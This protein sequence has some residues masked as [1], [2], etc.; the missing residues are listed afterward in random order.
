MTTYFST[1]IGTKLGTD[2][3]V[4]LYEVAIRPQG[5]E[6]SKI[7]G[8]TYRK[9]KVFLKVTFAQMSK[10]MQQ[11]ARFQ[12]K[13]LSIT[14]LTAQ[15]VELTHQ[16]P[17][18]PW[19]VEILTTEPRCLYYF[20]PFDNADEARF[21]QAGYL[22]DIQEEGAQGIAVQIKQCQPQILTQEW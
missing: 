8:L 18:L 21:H 20:G 1:K 5:T 13:I 6:F 11:I 17:Q 9:G 16:L 10:T 4:F 12:G 2:G 3:R 14:P 22:E 15:A 19:W 7:S